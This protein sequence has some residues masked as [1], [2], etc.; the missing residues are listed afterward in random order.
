MSQN[1][2]LLSILIPTYNYS[3]GLER[4]LKA[5]INVEKRYLAKVEFLISDDSNIAYEVKKIHDLCC[6]YKEQY[7]YNLIYLEG[8]KSS[9]PIDNWNSLIIKSNGLFRQIIHHDEFFGNYK[10]IEQLLDII[11]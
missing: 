10:D 3:Y 7:K 8:T 5:F 9:N 1:K 6:L 11:A 2:F 4:I